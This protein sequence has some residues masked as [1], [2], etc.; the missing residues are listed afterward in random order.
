MP[1]IALLVVGA[2]SLLLS[3]TTLEWYKT[4]K[5]TGDSIGKI[6]F[7]EL[8]HNLNSFPAQ[9]RPAAS[10]AYFGWLAWVLLIALIV[11]AFAANVPSKASDGLR[12]LGFFLGLVGLA[13]TYY[14]LARYAE[15]SHDL[16]GTS[17]GALDN[18]DLGIWCA[19]GGYVLA[20]LGA[21]LGPLPPKES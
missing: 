15:A 19:L 8:H 7:S 9:G 21:A 3:F 5:S 10:V 18:A 17:N 1:G 20:G 16:F 14:T 6:T 11:V 13:V 2:V 4:P 12:M